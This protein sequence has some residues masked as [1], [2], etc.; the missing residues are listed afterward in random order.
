MFHRIFHPSF[1]GPSFIR[2]HVPAPRRSRVRAESR[3]CATETANQ[4]LRGDWAAFVSELPPLG[5]VMILTRNEHATLASLRP[6][7]DIGRTPS[8]HWGV[9][10]DRSLSLDFQAWRRVTVL[11]QDSLAGLVRSFEVRDD[12]GNALHR[13]CLAPTSPPDAFEAL[14]AFHTQSAGQRSARDGSAKFGGAPWKPKLARRFT[15]L[16]TL[17]GSDAREV[18]PQRLSALLRT[19]QDARLPLRLQLLGQAANQTH[20]GSLD[21]FETRNHWIFCGDASGGLHLHPRGIVSLWLLTQVCPCCSREEWTLEAYDARQRLVLTI[22]SA[23]P[24][25]EAAWRELVVALFPVE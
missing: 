23:G 20:T 2:P 9:A 7:P 14:V 4:D 3:R 1:A 21:F 16:Q 25:H 19:V 18:T 6:Y 10:L 12:L 15:W 8:G 11:R 22:R 17:P 5:E 24:V 13:V